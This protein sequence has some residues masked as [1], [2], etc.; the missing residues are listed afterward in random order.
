M[1]CCRLGFLFTSD[2]GYGLRR[3]PF[4]RESGG[5]KNAGAARIAKLVGD[6]ACFAVILVMAFM[7]VAVN[8]KCGGNA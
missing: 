8:P 1:S 6:D 3:Q 4:L 7:V 5:F 2:K